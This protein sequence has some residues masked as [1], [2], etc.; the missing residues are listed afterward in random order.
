MKRLIN[1]FLDYLSVEKRYS[2]KTI[3]NYRIDLEQFSNYC[4]SNKINDVVSIE[5]DDLRKYLECLYNKEYSNKTISRHISSL[6]SFYKYLI[7]NEVITKNPTELL[8]N[9]K[10][11]FRLPNY[12]NIDD[13][14]KL[15]SIPKTETK[16]GKRDILIIEMF[17]STGIRLSELVNIKLKDINF[18]EK[19]IKIKGK[20]SK[21]RYVFYGREC[22]IYLDDYINNSRAFYLKG[23]NEYL[24]INQKG[25]KITQSGI[26]Y[27]IKKILD[28][29]G[30]KTHLT[31][32][33]LRHTFAT[34]MLN[35]GADLMTVKELLGHSNISTTGIYTHVSNEQLRRAYLN[36][37]PRARKEK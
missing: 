17:Y 14:D 19:S 29:S 37:H 9:P 10:A 27:I 33:V 2:D 18:N 3:D 4:L 6:K 24:F 23:D 31:P 5:Y 8:N 28:Q 34:H 22:E 15:I 32:H 26:E 21:E 11:E 36:A 35:E 25:N 16:T 13:L 7:N 30:I 12:L 1:D 20:G